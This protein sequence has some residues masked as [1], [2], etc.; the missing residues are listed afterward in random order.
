MVRRDTSGVDLE[1]LY[2]AVGKRN[3]TVVVIYKSGGHNPLGNWKGMASDYGLGF[4]VVN[5]RVV[6]LAGPPL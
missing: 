6:T 4:T 2:P 5:A 3:L 1:E